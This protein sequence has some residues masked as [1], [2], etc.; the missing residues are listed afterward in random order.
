M[1]TEM[2]YT[3]NVNHTNTKGLDEAVTTATDPYEACDGAHAVCILTEWDEFKEYDYERIYKS[4]AKP[5]FMFDG[6]NLIDAEKMRKIG[7]EVH[8]IGKPDPMT[9][10][11]L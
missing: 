10:T 8:S 2:D 9:F 6:R 11:D 5:A 3:C 1:W 7:F 4:M